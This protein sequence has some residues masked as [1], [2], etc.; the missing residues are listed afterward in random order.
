MIM[1]VL[2]RIQNPKPTTLVVTVR[3]MAM[4]TLLIPLVGLVV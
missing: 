2:M 4:G 1:V 3:R